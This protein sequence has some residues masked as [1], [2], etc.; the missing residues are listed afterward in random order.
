M[1]H[2]EPLITERLKQ[3][4]Q[5]GDD[6][7]DKPVRGRLQ[8][9]HSKMLTLLLEWYRNLVTGSR[10]GTTS[11]NYKRF[12]HSDLAHQLRGNSYHDDDMQTEF[13]A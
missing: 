12:D 9:R 2:P 1:E 4:A 11:S 7:P 8:H 5:Y 3:E 6:W 13:F 10:K